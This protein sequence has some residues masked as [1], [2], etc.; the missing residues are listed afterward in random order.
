MP[1]LSG[2]QASVYAL[3]VFVLTIALSLFLP[4]NPIVLS[5]LLVVIFLSVFVPTRSSTLIAG[6]ISAGVVLSTLR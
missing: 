5:G 2:R 1:Q 6:G 3:L 4:R